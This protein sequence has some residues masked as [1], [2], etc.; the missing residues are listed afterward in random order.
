MKTIFITITGGTV[1]R[2]ILRTGILSYLLKDENNRVVLLVPEKVD[3]YFIQEFSHPRVVFE[4]I[5]DI[6]N[7]SIRKFFTILFNG[8]TYTETEQ[9][10]LKFGGGDKGPESK[11]M[12]YIKHATFSLISRVKIFKYIARWVEQYIFIEKDFDFLFEK[13]K[14][15]LL[16]CSTMYSKLDVILIKA[17]KRFK[18]FS[19]SMPKSWD[20]V[21]RLFF[22][23]PSDAIVVN[24][25]FMKDWIV[26][27]QGLAGENIFIC[28]I[29]QFDVYK[30]KTEFLTK[31]VFC[32]KT[33]L[34][35]YKPIVLFA[36][37]GKWTWWD[38]AYVDELIHKYNIL[39]NYNLILRPHFSNLQEKKYHKFAHMKGVYID[40]THLRTSRAFAD[41]WDPSRENMEWF[42]EVLHQS[43]V[44]IAFMSTVVLDAFA[45]DRPVI[46][47]C[48]DLPVE[49][50]TIPLKELYNSVHFNAVRKEN[51]T[52]IA[53]SAQEVMNWIETCVREPNI[54]IQERQNTLH[55]IAYKIDG[56]SAKRVAEVILSH[57]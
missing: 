2:N 54:F 12:Y 40:D 31:G 26:S 18:V 27:E 1:A 6:K 35:P 8:L 15:T 41:H 11:S 42:A 46:N 56:Q 19:I 36:S 3:D 4:K 50:P 20:T 43:S 33:G 10:M 38:D 51:P 25:P 22:R 30:Q 17:G 39:K 44:V 5:P 29:P 49:G 9:R 7:S 24:N 28:G 37:E 45:C 48:Y 55:S 23:A 47:L 16:F 14:P 34:D 32:S 13:Y 57:L 52:A 53:E 21:G